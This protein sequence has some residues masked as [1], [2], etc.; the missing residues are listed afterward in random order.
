MLAKF[1]GVDSERTVSIVGLEKK[2]N[3]C[4]CVHLLNKEAREIRKFHTVVAVIM[5]VISNMTSN[6]SSLL[7]NI[8]DGEHRSLSSFCV[9]LRTSEF[10]SSVLYM[11][12]LYKYYQS[13]MKISEKLSKSCLFLPRL[14][15]GIRDFQ[16]KSGQ[17]R[18]DRDNGIN[19]FAS[20]L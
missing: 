7:T 19:R 17:S 6:F 2:E 15:I 18:P 1:S 11:M 4:V 13:R 8:K 9:A 5:H 14:H 10:Q 3:I 16:A 20:W 12:F